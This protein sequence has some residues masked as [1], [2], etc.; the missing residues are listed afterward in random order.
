MEALSAAMRTS[1]MRA[2]SSPA[3]TAGPWILATTGRSISSRIRGMRW[4]PFHREFFRARAVEV[5]SSWL[6]KKPSPAAMA[7][8]SPPAQKAL[9]L[10]DRSTA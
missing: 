4:M 8:T 1:H 6:S 5:M 3:P 9:P 10:P 2:I 7:F